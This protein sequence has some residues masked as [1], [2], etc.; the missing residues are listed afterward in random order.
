VVKYQFYFKAGYVGK[1]PNATRI[2]CFI[3]S[4]MNNVNHR[5]KTGKQFLISASVFLRK[6]QKMYFFEKTVF[7]PKMVESEN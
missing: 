4:L 3:S 7:P 6:I 1:R 5:D 2:A